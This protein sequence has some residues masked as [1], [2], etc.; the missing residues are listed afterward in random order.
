MVIP[1]VLIK[2]IIYPYIVYNKTDDDLKRQ[3]RFEDPI[4]SIRFPK[5]GGD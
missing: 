5:G 2:I 1:E 3:K 4:P